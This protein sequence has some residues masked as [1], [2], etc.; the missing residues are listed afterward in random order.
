M[1][2]PN[3]KDTLVSWRKSENLSQ[4]M[5]A[6][7]LGVSQ[8]TVSRW[9]RGID[10]PKAGFFDLIKSRM[11]KSD[12]FTID[13]QLVEKQL[14][15]RALFDFDGMQ[16]LHTSSGFKNCWPN[17]AEMKNKYMQDILI[18]GISNIYADSNLV[19][20]V[21]RKELIAASGVALKQLDLN[22]DPDFNHNWYVRFRNY[23]SRIIGDITIE[24]AKD[25]QQATHQF[26]ILSD[27]FNIKI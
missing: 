20:A 16:I 14:G 19:K 12:A 18:G 15:V 10:L 8:Q 22:C 26:Y 1:L 23:G 24:A 9:E 13:S 11:S 5:L 17:L 6:N 4:Q 3:F 2:K 27:Q 7:I 21:Y 25:A